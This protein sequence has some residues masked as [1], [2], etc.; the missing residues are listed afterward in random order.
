MLV[1]RRQHISWPKSSSEIDKIKAG[2]FSIQGLPNVCGAMD[3]T[4]IVMERPHGE[5][6]LNWYNR[7]KDYSMLVQVVVDAN[8]SFSD[9]F[10]GFPGS[11]NDTRLL[12]NLALYLSV[13]R[14]LILNGAE[15]GQGSFS[16][17]EFIV[18]DG[19]YPLLPWLM[20]PYTNPTIAMKNFST[21]SYHQP[22]LW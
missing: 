3:A 1:H 2:F 12:K 17:R 13:E 20:I 11:I 14:R 4:H 10:A 19:G 7:N 9:V 16:I 6:D 15:Y 22:E 5:L 21:T 8:M 18:A